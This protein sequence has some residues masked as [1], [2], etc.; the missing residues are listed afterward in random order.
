MNRVFFQ[1]LCMVLFAGS[2]F[3]EVAESKGEVFRDDTFTTRAGGATSNKA[4]GYQKYQK[5]YS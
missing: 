1:N 5:S 3:F 2:N 4:G